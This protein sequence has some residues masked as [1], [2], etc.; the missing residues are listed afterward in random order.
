M[1]LTK[2]KTLKKIEVIPTVDDA[3]H[4]PAVFEKIVVHYRVIIEDTS[5]GM[6]QRVVHEDVWLKGQD[7]SEE[8]EVVRMIAEAIWP[9]EEEINE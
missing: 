1:A 2:I 3:L 4:P 6:T 8:P 9:M 7:L 5:D